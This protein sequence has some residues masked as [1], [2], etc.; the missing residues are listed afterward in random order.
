VSAE[1][2]PRRGRRGEKGEVGERGLQGDRGE[3]GARGLAGTLL[4]AEGDTILQRMVRNTTKR[5]YT[6]TNEMNVTLQTRAVTNKRQRTDQ[7]HIHE[8]PRATY[9]STRHEH[10]HRYAVEAPIFHTSLR[11]QPRVSVRRSVHLEVYAPV[12]FQR[13]KNE[14]RVTRPIFV[15]AN[16]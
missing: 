14:S 11:S 4:L 1:I 5:S 16:W 9:K 6:S 7:L 10:T 8:G 12:L 15:F 2:Q 13:I 3:K